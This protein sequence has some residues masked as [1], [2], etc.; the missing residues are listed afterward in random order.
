M[1]QYAT[2]NEQLADLIA[3]IDSPKLVPWCFIDPLDKDAPKQA[4][5]WLTQ[6]RMKGV[7]MYPPMGWYPDDPRAIEVFKVIARLDVPVLLHMGRVAPHP[8]LRTKYG[9]PLCLEDV[10]LACP[11]IKL[12]IGHWANMWRWEAFH[13]AMSFPNFFFDLTTSGSL[14][15]P[16]IQETIRH[17]CLGLAR[18]VLG[19]DGS[20][21]GNLQL[22]K[23]TLARL[24]SAGGLSDAQ[25]DA[26]A[27]HNGLAVLGEQS[28]F[29]RT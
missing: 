28:P 3:R 17:E 19:T 14:H 23:A 11:N 25:V 18:I 8:G 15:L 29:P 27:H 24:K 2:T 26:V 4:E 12:I 9:R 20:G 6:G 13:I 16:I 5:Y 21:A 7:K 1:S 22:A 10:G